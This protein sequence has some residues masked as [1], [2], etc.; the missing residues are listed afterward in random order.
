MVSVCMASHNGEQYIFD[1]VNSILTQLDKEDELII[2]DDGSDDR[3]LEI[4]Q[5]INDKRVRI[6]R[7]TQES[8]ISDKKLK[9][10]YYASANFINALQ[11]A[12]GE[13][14]L[15]SDQDDIW[16]K[17]K[18]DICKKALQEYDIIKHNFSIID[19][20]GI[21]LQEQV[22]SSSDYTN[23]T[24]INS[25][26][27]LPFRGCCLAFK[28]EILENCLPFPK[29]C[30]QHDIWIGMVALLNN[31]NFGFVDQDLI[32]HRVHEDNVSELSSPNTFLFKIKYRIKLILNLIVYQVKR[33]KQREHKMSQNG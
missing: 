7:Y 3:T 16:V 9:G 20:D 28:R 29:K 17:G 8:S 10:F 19:K 27:Y 12:K 33:R 21:L 32:L 31:F 30:F 26:K 6:I 1:Q 13:I 15:L 14:I 18:I 5:T 24:V 11:Y 4:L 22:C 23:M 25:L 2:S